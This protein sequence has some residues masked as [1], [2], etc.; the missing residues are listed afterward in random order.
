MSKWNVY[1]VQSLIGRALLAWPIIAMTSIVLAILVL[2][3]AIAEG[4]CEAGRTLKAEWSR[5][6]DLYDFAAP[7]LFLR[8]Q[9]HE[10]TV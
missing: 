5:T 7:A 10:V 2:F 6:R 1:R 9:D 8:R 3:T 4:V